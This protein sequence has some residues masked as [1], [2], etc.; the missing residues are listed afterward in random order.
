MRR[1]SNINWAAFLLGGFLWALFNKFYLW[2]VPWVLIGIAANLLLASG[3]NDSILFTYAGSFL[4]TLITAYLAFNGNNMLSKRVIR[5]ELSPESELKE[6]AVIYGRQRTQIMWGIILR[7]A[8]YAWTGYLLYV[9][10]ISTY[11]FF[12]PIM[13][14]AFLVVTT[15]ILAAK[16]HSGKNELF[17]EGK[18][19]YDLLIREAR[20]AKL[21]E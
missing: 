15:L 16:F 3:L 17:S 20:R 18:A 8:L 10:T 19:K 5:M 4:G 11:G 2:I 12:V 7:T 9:D 21:Q 14:D 1:F 6:R 13:L